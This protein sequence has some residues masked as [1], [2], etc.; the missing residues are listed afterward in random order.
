MPLAIQNGTLVLKE[1]SL[2]QSPSCCCDDPA[3][4]CCCA[5]TLAEG[6]TPLEF[7]GFPFS[8]IGPRISGPFTRGVTAVPNKCQH[9]PHISVAKACSAATNVGIIIEWCNISL[10]TQASGPLPAQPAFCNEPLTYNDTYV[11]SV[12]PLPPVGPDTPV[13]YTLQLS[14]A[15]PPN[16][17]QTVVFSQCGRC[18]VL[19]QVRWLASGWDS[20][21]GHSWGLGKNIHFFRRE[22]CDSEVITG[23]YRDDA[24]G[25][26]WGAAGTNTSALS[27]CPELPEI[28]VTFAP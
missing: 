12:T 13:G 8:G 7:T 15:V 17:Q 5:G 19:G 16:E 25:F 22:G 4:F 24:S 2:G 11:C 10:Q 21:P 3:V 14:A 9:I 28:T 18:F 26:V 1:G 6:D 27:V 23:L 20:P